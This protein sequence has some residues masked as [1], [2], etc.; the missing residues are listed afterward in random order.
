MCVS[1][2]NCPDS[3][4]CFDHC[5]AFQFFHGI[6]NSSL[7]QKFNQM[8]VFIHLLNLDMCSSTPLFDVCNNY[9]ATGL[10]SLIDGDNPKSCMQVHISYN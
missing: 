3:N 6:W 7:L 1:R 9:L 8:L 2:C 5:T 10:T 4:L